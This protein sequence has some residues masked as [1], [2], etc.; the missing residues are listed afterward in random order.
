MA[1]NNIFLWL[2]LA[3]MASGVLLELL[4]DA[5]IKE[6]DITKE[7]WRELSSEIATRRK[8]AM[9]RIKAH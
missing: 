1:T 7:Q 5:G 3:D 2:M 6:G 4:A 8:A 9:A